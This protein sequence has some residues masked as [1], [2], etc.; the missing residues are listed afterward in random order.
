M[1]VLGGNVHAVVPNR[2]FRSAQL[3]STALGDVLER[4]HIRTVINLRGGWSGKSAEEAA[5]ASRDIKHVD[6]PMSALALPPP[7][8]L[9]RLLEVF[10]TS[11]YPILF[12]CQGGADRSGLVGTLYL[13]L[14]EHV[15]LD[16]AE[17]RQLTWRHGHF[18]VGATHA[19]DDFFD[20]YRRTGKGQQLREWI[21]SDYPA[22]YEERQPA[23]P[24][25]PR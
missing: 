16:L 6:V 11:A 5:C 7:E 13:A 4:E 14:Y 12:H 22:L 15:P 1:G 8:R 3:S 19:M 24:R 9:K 20:L 2:V 23:G 18:P 25:R 17:E 10:D 21:L